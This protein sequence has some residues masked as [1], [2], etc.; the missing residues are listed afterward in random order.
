MSR[1]SHEARAALRLLAAKAL[2][3][4]LREGIATCRATGHTDDEIAALIAGVVK[5]K[6]A[7][8]RRKRAVRVVP[9]A[10]A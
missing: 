1:I 4:D 10:A 9:E 5:E 8:P 3:I 2:C 7:A 6:A